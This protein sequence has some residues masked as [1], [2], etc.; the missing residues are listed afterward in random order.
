MAVTDLANRMRTAVWPRSFACPSFRLSTFQELFPRRLRLLSSG[1]RCV[2][3]L[4][5]ESPA[6]LQTQN[7]IMTPPDA[8]QISKSQAA[9]L[10]GQ[11]HDHGDTPGMAHDTHA[12]MLQRQG[13]KAKRKLALHV[14]YCGTG[15][16]GDPSD[17]APTHASLHPPK[18][19]KVST[20]VARLPGRPCTMRHPS[21][22]QCRAAAA[23]GGE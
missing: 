5:A 11:E 1:V 4:I 7:P 16:A 9:P 19:C 8:T 18:A 20:P 3:Q 23:E 15:F 10:S 17:S 14:A 6:P 13:A 12:P 2:H 22:W 21:A